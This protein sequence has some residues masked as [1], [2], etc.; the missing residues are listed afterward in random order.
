M[1]LAWRTWSRCWR[2]F[3]RCPPSRTFDWTTTPSRPCSARTSSSS[4]RPFRT[5]WSFRPSKRSATTSK[6]STTRWSTYFCS[7]F[8]N[9]RNRDLDVLFKILSTTPWCCKNITLK[10][11]SVFLII[12]FFYLRGLLYNPYISPT[13][14]GASFENL[15]PVYFLATSKK[16][17]T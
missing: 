17:I 8:E 5:G 1:I 16:I 7:R 6:L 12:I 11:A 4:P 10:F 13:L 2:T 14:I 15:C 3:R 9:R